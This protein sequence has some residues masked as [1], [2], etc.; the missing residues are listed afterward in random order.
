MNKLKI[1]NIKEAL[2]RAEHLRNMYER[3]I[4]P[5][6]ESIL[7]LYKMLEYNYGYGNVPDTLDPN[8][9]KKLER[10]MMKCVDMFNETKDISEELGTLISRNMGNK[11]NHEF[12]SGIITRSK[13]KLLKFVGHLK[14][15]AKYFRSK[16]Y[17]N[18]DDE[19]TK[20]MIQKYNL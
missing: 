11:F 3:D 14:A 12:E 15:I 1:V 18:L 2:L 8:E 19:G 20:I 4:W 17:L 5:L 10:Y 13:D 16:G 6:M 9:D 7:D